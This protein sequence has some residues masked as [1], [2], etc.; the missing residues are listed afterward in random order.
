[1]K[2][3]KSSFHTKSNHMQIE[4]YNIDKH[5]MIQQMNTTHMY[6]DVS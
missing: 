6:T 5:K 2:K 1:M 4:E 3:P